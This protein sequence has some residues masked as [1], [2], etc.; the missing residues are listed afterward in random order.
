VN[1]VARE[2][3]KKKADAVCG[4]GKP[5]E[6]CFFVGAFV[7]SGSFTTLSV[8]ELHGGQTANTL[9]STVIPSLGFR[10]PISPSGRFTLELGFLSMY[11]SKEVSATNQRN[12]CRRSDGDFER[13]LPCEG[14]VSISP[15][16]G[17][18]AGATV[19]T[20]DI[21]LVTIMPMAGFATTSLDD[22]VR[23]YAG[24]AIGLLNVS[25]V[26]NP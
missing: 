10:T 20:Q 11:I 16:V 3:V 22:S 7:A 14:S 23:P 2:T 13:H 6:Y 25:K 19:G 15:V 9:V 26:F 17:L 8:G 12:G 21:G 24:L 5:W 1:D 18:Y 4:S